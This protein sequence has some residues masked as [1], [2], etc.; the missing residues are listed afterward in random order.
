MVHITMVHYLTLHLGK[1]RNSN[2]TETKTISYEL[3][4]A[5]TYPYSVF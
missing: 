3:A 1:L 5:N 2:T 4:F